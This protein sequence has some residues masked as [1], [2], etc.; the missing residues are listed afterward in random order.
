MQY[1]YLLFDFINMYMRRGSFT[2]KLNYLTLP[3]V[4][5]LILYFRKSELTRMGAGINCDV[6]C[7]CEN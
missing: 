2:I 7:L 4:R 6:I 5:H 1:M 3:E